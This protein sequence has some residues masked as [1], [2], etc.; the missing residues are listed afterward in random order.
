MGWDDR[1]RTSDRESE[2]S[3]GRLQKVKIG[4]LAVLSLNG[5]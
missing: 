4:F 2:A 3:I 5:N 1:R